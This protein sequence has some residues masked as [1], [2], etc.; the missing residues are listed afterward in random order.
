MPVTNWNRPVLIVLF[1]LFVAA[2]TVYLQ[3][4]PGL[5]GDE[6]SEGENVYQ[7]L[8]TG[9]ITVVGERSYIGPLVD[10]VRVPFVLIFGYSEI[11]RASCRERV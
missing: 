3:R 10:Y 1:A 9:G 6:G 4:V 8:R 11:G 2:N 7:L 5:F